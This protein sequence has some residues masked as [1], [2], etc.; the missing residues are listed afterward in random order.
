LEIDAGTGVGILLGLLVIIL[1][2]DDFYKTVVTVLRLRD[3]VLGLA[4][5]LPKEGLVAI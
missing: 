2:S 4:S 5:G 1:P 3:L